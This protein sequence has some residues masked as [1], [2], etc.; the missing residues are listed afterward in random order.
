VVTCPIC[1]RRFDERAYQVII[2]GLG[3]FDSIDCV[4][5]ALHRR[6]RDRRAL[7][8]GP[9]T[10]ISSTREKTPKRGEPIPTDYEN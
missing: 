6:A 9:T 10:I 4:E 7:A 2:V 1:E 5:A 8:A 3:S